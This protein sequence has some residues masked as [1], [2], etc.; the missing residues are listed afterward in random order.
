MAFDFERGAAAQDGGQPL[1]V[2]KK[3]WDEPR[4]PTY[5][6][7]LVAAVKAAAVAQSA[8]L[9]ADNASIS[10]QPNKLNLLISA[11]QQQQRPDTTG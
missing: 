10:L 8:K 1:R 7:R 9:K 11:Q 3:V 5:P 2:V 6:T 4:A